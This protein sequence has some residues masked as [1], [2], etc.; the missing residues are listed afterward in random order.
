MSEGKL[1]GRLADPHG[2]LLDSMAHV[3]AAIEASSVSKSSAPVGLE[4]NPTGTAENDSSVIL[5]TVQEGGRT[6]SP[7]MAP[8]STRALPSWTLSRRW[9]RG[10]AEHTIPT[11]DTPA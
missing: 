6:C 9:A 8:R 3:A 11:P 4:E 1:V 7:P 5:S 10:C 2:V